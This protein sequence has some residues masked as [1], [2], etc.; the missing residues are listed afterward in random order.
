MKEY[1]YWNKARVISLIIAGVYI[2]MGWFFF[3]EGIVKLFGLIA[4]ALA[5]IWFGD[6]LGQ[7]EAPSRGGYIRATP[8]FFMRIAGWALLFLPAILVLV[9]I[10]SKYLY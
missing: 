9:G 4:F 1:L 10:F 6:E 2:V 5:G 3:K 8:G 7:Y